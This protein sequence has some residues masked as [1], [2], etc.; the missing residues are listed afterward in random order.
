VLR[1]RDRRIPLRPGETHI[2]RSPDCEVSINDHLMSR[3]HARVV[4][5]A[6]GVTIEDLESANG[7]FVNGSRIRG[8]HR[9]AVGDKLRLGTQVLELAALTQPGSP[10]SYSLT[11]ET[12]GGSEKITL[13]EEVPSTGRV[14]SSR[15]P[16]ESVSGIVVPPSSDAPSGTRASREPLKDARGTGGAPS[17]DVPASLRRTGRM[18]FDGPASQAPSSPR[19]SSKPGSSGAG[20]A[21]SRAPG[22][23]AAGGRGLSSRPPGGLQVTAFQAAL[24]M[25]AIEDAERLVAAELM[26]IRERASSGGRLPAE[27]AEAAAA[28]AVK[29][30]AATE[31]P[32]WIDYVISLYSL[33]ERALPVQ[34]I[35]ELYAVLGSVRQIDLTALRAYV[36]KLD[37]GATTPADRFMVQQISGLERRVTQK[38]ASST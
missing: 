8:S 28:C 7:T 27:L 17:S 35:D 18:S 1:Y 22:V 4:V 2:G 9:L 19:P 20:R 30:A 29:L 11:A 24:A 3:R 37:R 36:L 32:M 10:G 21:S 16:A 6:E 13:V 25:G 31:K 34:V 14:P 38:P 26:G 5:D 23:P 15:P 12:A 33:I